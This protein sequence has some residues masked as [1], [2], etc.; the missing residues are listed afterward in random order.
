MNTNDDYDYCETCG[1]LIQKGNAYVSIT[2][3]IEQIEHNLIENEDEVQ[4]I[5]SVELIRLCGACGNMFD[6]EILKTL[7]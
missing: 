7:H 5:D 3:N 6:V 1:K 2:R 4:V